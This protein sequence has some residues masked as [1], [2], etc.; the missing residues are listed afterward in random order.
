M[1][2]VTIEHDYL[3]DKGGRKARGKRHKVI[4]AAKALTAAAISPR[5]TNHANGA[6]PCA[7]A[8]RYAKPIQCKRSCRSVATFI[9][10]GF[11]ASF[12]FN[13]EL[14]VRF[15]CVFVLYFWTL[16][17]G[18]MYFERLIWWCYCEVTATVTV[19]RWFLL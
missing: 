7:R 14:F 12:V 8:A 2:I 5:S 17:G 6:G 16:Y 11:P 15:G 13:Y 1:S 9:R 4:W 3:S 10:P 18:L 19:I